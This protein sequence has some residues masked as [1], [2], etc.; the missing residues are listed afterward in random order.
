MNSS[1]IWLSLTG[2]YTASYAVSQVGYTKDFPTCYQVCGHVALSSVLV[3]HP[4]SQDM[5]SPSCSCCSYS[6]L[7]TPVLLTVI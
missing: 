2:S 3:Y 1:H 6:F 4:G 5:I 7:E